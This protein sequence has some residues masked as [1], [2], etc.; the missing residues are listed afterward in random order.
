MPLRDNFASTP[1]SLTPF[2]NQSHASININVA[3]PTIDNPVFSPPFPSP[4]LVEDQNCPRDILIKR[5]TNGNHME[6][7]DSP[8]GANQSSCSTNLS[9]IDA[10]GRRKETQPIHV[11]YNVGN[12]MI[13]ILA[14]HAFNFDPIYGFSS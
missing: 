3:D 9:E 5:A 8:N 11:G 12:I 14:P 1:P 4:L 13:F 10:P 6:T 7:I 2:V